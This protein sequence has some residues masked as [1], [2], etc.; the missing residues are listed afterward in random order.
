MKL[1]IL[2]EDDEVL[3]LD[4]PSDLV[5]TDL[6]AEITK[7]HPTATLAH[8][9]DRDTTGVIIVAKHERAYKYL[10]KQFQDRKVKK[11]YQ[12]IVVGE[13]LPESGR[14]TGTINVPIGRHP[15]DAR[16][17]AT[18]K[19]AEEPRREAITHYRIIKNYKY[20]ADG[21]DIASFTHLEARPETGRTHQLRVH[22]KQLGHPI[23]HDTL[24]A[25]FTVR[26]PALKRQ[27]LHA[28]KLAL[29]LPSGLEKEFIAPIPPD[30]QQALAEL[31]QA[32][33]LV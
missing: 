12:A 19:R 16:R 21:T 25:P 3:V 11:S 10:K 8:R 4:K 28:H 1:K 32:N 14:P 17:R 6:L 9:L 2:Y 30:F 26:P 23:A 5:V 20:K 24:Y 13:L 15:S 29:K 31:D 18:G 27:A 7:K 22:F 33:L